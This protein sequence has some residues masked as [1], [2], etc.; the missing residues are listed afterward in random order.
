MSSTKHVVIIGNGVAG[1]TAARHVRKLADHAIII[2]S[3]ESDHFYSRTALMYIYMGHMTYEHT[4]PYEDGFWEKNRIGLVRGFVETIETDA[5]RLRLADGRTIGYDVLIVATGSKS[6]KFGWPGENLDGVGGLYNLGDL[7]SMERNTKGVDRAVV[8]GGGLI[9]VET[10]EMLR[11]RNIH[12]TLLAREKTYFNNV[13]PSEEGVILGRHIREHGVDLRLETELREIVDDGAGRVAG[14]VTSRGEHIPCGFVALTVGVT[15]NIG[16]VKGSPIETA[17]GVLVNEYF[18]TNVPDV[19]AVGDCA[20]FREPQP[21]H[22]RV[23]QLWYTGKM[24]GEVVARTICGARTAYR[25]GV[26]FNSAKFFD[27]EYQTYGFVW[28][29][30]REGEETLLWE[31]PDGHA[32]IRINYAAAGRRVLGFNLLGVRYRHAVCERWIAEGATIEHV[33]ENL[34]AANFDP[35]FFDQFERDV[36]RSYNM[37]GDVEPIT[38]KRKRGFF[39]N[40]FQ[41]RKSS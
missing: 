31:R 10:A 34:G 24:H 38:L 32:C 12:V 15:P 20:E 23:E 35:E 37:R 4:K 2:I 30:L 6:N 16:V 9:G 1:V 13:L 40:M 39:S 36:V 3:A 21:D 8:V 14:V 26:W 29:S 22:P 11:S 5:K 7:E 33:L 25:R 28:P 41:T 19:Y 18:E 17:R 27:I